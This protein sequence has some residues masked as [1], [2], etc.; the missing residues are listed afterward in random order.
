MRDYKASFEY[1]QASFNDWVE[2]EKAK[3]TDEQ[4]KT[5]YD[6]RVALGQLKFDPALEKA[7]TPEAPGETPADKPAEG[8]TEKPADAPATTEPAPATEP[9]K[10]EPAPEI[11]QRLLLSL[12]RPSQPR[13]SLQSQRKPNRR[14]SLNQQSQRAQNLQAQN[15]RVPSQSRPRLNHLRNRHRILTAMVYRRFDWLL[16]KTNPNQRKRNRQRKSQPVQRNLLLRPLPRRNL[17][18]HTDRSDLPPVVVQPDA[19]ASSATEAKPADE[20][21]PADGKP[22]DEKPAEATGTEPAAPADGAAKPELRTKTFEEARPELLKELAQNAAIDALEKALTGINEQMLKY[23][24]AHAA[25]AAMAREGIQSE[26]KATR[27]DLKKLAAD[28]G[29]LYGETVS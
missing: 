14:L 4:L 24:T 16:L 21:K 22:G 28:V 27:P 20:T 17:L 1:V 23:S 3:I 11:L 29:L 9:A 6:K 10:T 19:P 25:Q 2:R 26:S 13:L 8:S 12:P 18:L 15:Q 5:E 7:K